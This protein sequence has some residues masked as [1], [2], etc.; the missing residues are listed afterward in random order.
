MDQHPPADPCSAESP[1]APNH[2]KD[3]F[4]PEIH[5]NYGNFY[6]DNA[7]LETFCY[8][9]SGKSYFLYENVSKKGG[10]LY[11]MKD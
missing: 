10:G 5:S 7:I 8:K 9:L 6:L 2:K 11:V 1:N 3:T 4:S